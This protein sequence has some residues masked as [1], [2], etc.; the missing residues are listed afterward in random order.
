[1]VAGAGLGGG[2]LGVIQ[3]N[4]FSSQVAIAT[5]KTSVAD[6]LTQRRVE[7]KE[8]IDWNR[9]L[10]F[11]LFGGLY[12]GVIQWLLYVRLYQRLFGSAMMK[13]INQP[14]RQKL[15][16]KAGL[17]ALGGQI[18]LDLAVI[19]PIL[20][21]PSLYIFKAGLDQNL[22]SLKDKM[23]SAFVMWKTNFIEDNLYMIG[24]WLVLDVFL[25]GFTPIYL[26]LPFNHI[27]SFLWCLILSGLR[28]DEKAADA[29]VAAA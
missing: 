2:L 12:L 4:P 7:K 19:T 28:G 11:V 25:Y 18:V 23:A 5:A 6:L 15:Q 17:R 29:Q 21:W 3:A 9:N 16:N 14:L 8:K 26:R 24:F 22:V 13:F 10:S 27:A 1:M 20:Y